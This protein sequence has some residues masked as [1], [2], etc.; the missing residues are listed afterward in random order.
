MEIV[1]AIF[2]KKSSKYEYSCNDIYLLIE[3]CESFK[4]ND[5]KEN[6]QLELTFTLDNQHFL[7]DD[8]EKQYK[9]NNVVSD[10]KKIVKNSDKIYN[11]KNFNIDK[12]DEIIDR[13]LREII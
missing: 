12:F 1:G 2:N 3:I 6:Y 10:L 9:S 7:V 11:V 4:R 8:F 13:W 5:F